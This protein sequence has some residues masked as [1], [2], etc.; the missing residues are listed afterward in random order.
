MN[1]KIN[2]KCFIVFQKKEVKE[3]SGSQMA[4]LKFSSYIALKERNFEKQE[5]MAPASTSLKN[6]SEESE[7][8]ATT[9]KKKEERRWQEFKKRN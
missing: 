3:S 2:F 7:A 8:P 6:Y 4:L 9:K 1:P 5:E